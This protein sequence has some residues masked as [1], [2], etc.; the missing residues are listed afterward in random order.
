MAKNESLRRDWPLGS[1]LG[2]ASS[3]GLS[4]VLLPSEPVAG[5]GGQ[6]HWPCSFVDQSRCH[7]LIP[8]LTR[9]ATWNPRILKVDKI[10][11]PSCPAF[12]QSAFHWA[13]VLMKHNQSLRGYHAACHQHPNGRLQVTW[14][15]G[16]RFPGTGVDFFIF[17]ST[18]ASFGRGTSLLLNIYSLY[19]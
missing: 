18:S 12:L 10:C 3:G 2:G 4:L 6:A 17:S 11:P 5:G 7:C 14:E 13:L 19:F 16:G 1:S 15:E 9:W 8:F